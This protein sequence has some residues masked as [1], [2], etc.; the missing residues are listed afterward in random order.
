MRSLLRFC[1]PALIGSLC[2]LWLLPTLA[3]EPEG[4]AEQPQNAAEKPEA[5]A[6]DAA[7]P[8]AA[9]QKEMKKPAAESKPA[10]PDESNESEKAEKSADEKSKKTSDK[11]AAAKDGKT[12]EKATANKASE[13]AKKP[14]PVPYTSGI[15]WAEPE[16]VDPGSEAGAPPSDAIVLFDG[17]NLDAWD[18]DT[19]KWSLQDGYGIAGSM[20]RTKQPF[21]DCQ[22]HLEF[23]CPEEDTGKGQQKGNNG[24]G[25]MDAKYEIQVL[26]SHTNTTYFDGQA[27]AL[28]KQH[29]PLV[30]ASRPT[31]QWQTYDILFTAPRFYDDG[32][33]KRPAY[34]TVLHNGVVVQLNY[35]LKGTTFFMTP[36]SYEKHP[37]KLPLV[38]MY[39]GDPVR[40][41][42]IWVRD[43]SGDAG[44]AQL[45]SDDAEKTAQSMSKPAK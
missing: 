25:L 32:S 4:N 14:R 44:K 29:P 17:S 37:E 20:I 42:N 43:L 10:K 24:I 6:K 28:Y 13:E 39:H 15:N 33:L 26:D 34:V 1:R 2:C 19:G 22:L 36:P 38:L 40:F 23:Q 16:K 21:G 27:A 9:K 30:N 11:P 18:G 8:D 35:E 45:A 12:A 31:G 5:S 41:R 3:D 7:K